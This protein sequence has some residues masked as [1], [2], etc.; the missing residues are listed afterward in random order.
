LS[1]P[2]PTNWHDAEPIAAYLREEARL[3]PQLIDAE[4]SRFAAVDA[5]AS[6]VR[7]LAHD[8]TEDRSRQGAARRLRE[9]ELFL[10]ANHVRAVRDEALK[11]QL[12]SFKGAAPQLGYVQLDRQPEIGHAF[13][14]SRNDWEDWV[15]RSACWE[16]IESEA[17][18]LLAV[19]REQQAR[20]EAASAAAD[21]ALEAMD[22][23]VRRALDL[24]RTTFRGGRTAAKLSGAPL[25]AFVLVGLA[26]AALEPSPAAGWTAVAFLLLV[27]LGT[28]T[29]FFLREDFRGLSAATFGVGSSLSVFAAAYLAARVIR[30]HDLI[31]AGAPISSLGEAA[32]T[33][34]TVGITGGTIGVD[35]GGAAR[36]IAFIQI[37]L[38]VA[39]VVAG[40]A[41][42]WRHLA[43][44]ADSLP[45]GVSNG[46]PDEQPG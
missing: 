13:G 44:R 7:E 26:G 35:L 8:L 17:L 41:W 25:A 9:E 36:I 16:E 18:R 2:E 31:H 3:L 15:K 34:L 43:D 4:I 46:V 11:R 5:K 14:R 30:P 38:T 20:R 6:K 39:A 12:V 1:L 45:D 22:M 33:S 21:R 19:A 42:A 23:T 28:S 32:F 40:I 29:V 24:S 10:A 27:V 37:L